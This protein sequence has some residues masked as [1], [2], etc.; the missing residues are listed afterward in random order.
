MT[1]EYRTP[2]QVAPSIITTSMLT[3]SSS[4][5]A[6]LEAVKSV[7]IPLMKRMRRSE[8]YM[9]QFLRSVYTA[10]TGVETVYLV[11]NKLEVREAKFRDWA[12]LKT[13]RHGV[14]GGGQLFHTTQRYFDQCQARNMAGGILRIVF[15]EMT[16]RAG[17]DVTTEQA[18][19]LYNEAL[20]RP[21]SRRATEADIIVG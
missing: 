15:V 4:D 5:Q 1:S 20:E 9:A 17:R 18:L 16:K 10:F 2:Y 7:A 13:H 3:H 19:E 12:M 8:Y 14:A 11:T 6:D 21:R